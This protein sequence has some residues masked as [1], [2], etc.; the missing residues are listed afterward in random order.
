MKNISLTLLTAVAFLLPPLGH[1]SQGHTSTIEK[2]SD[3]RLAL[4]SSKAANVTTQSYQS[5]VWFHSIELFLS[6]DL[7]DNGYYHRLEIELDADTSL[8]YQQVFAE[9]S[10]WPGY[11]AE[12]VYYTSSVFEL[13]GQSADDWLAIDT[14]LE[15]QFAADDYLLTV[16]LFDAASGYL[17]AEI[18]GF[19]DSSL[20]Y[21]PLEDYSRDSYIRGSVE[22]SAG[23][24]GILLFSALC[25]LLWQRRYVSNIK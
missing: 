7:N 24:T 4:K 23:S 21:I 19:D 16:R 12:R 13:Y 14:V 22:V 25:L 17:L 8:P 1:A 3:Q 10:L 5:H 2:R 11:G 9:F 6:G 15:H 20:D 18:S